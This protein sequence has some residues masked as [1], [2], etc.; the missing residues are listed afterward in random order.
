MVLQFIDLGMRHA[1]LLCVF[2]C[3]VV[4]VAASG[5]RAGDPSPQPQAPAPGRQD[6]TATRRQDAP[7]P[8]RQAGVPQSEQALVKQY[9]VTCH[10]AR[11]VT[12]GLSL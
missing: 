11:V 5:L 9:C 1:S 12:G 6:A 3:W 10:N 8:S 4:A 7:A 2:A